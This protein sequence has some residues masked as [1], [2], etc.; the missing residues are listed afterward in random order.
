VP[1]KSAASSAHDYII[2][3]AG[4][5]GCV[6]ANRL[7]EDADASVLLVEAGGE[8]R[9]PFARMPLANPYFFHRPDINWNYQSER[10]PGL[11]G[12]Q[13][14]LP[15]G[16]VL[17]GSS[18]I[19]GMAF[20]RGHRRD[21]DDWSDQGAEGWSYSEVLPYFRRLETSWAGANEYHGDSGPV[22]IERALHRSLRFEELRDAALAA[23]H[24]ETPDYHGEVSEGITRPE[25]TTASGRRSD[26]AQ[27][28]LKPALRRRN[29]TLL[30]HATVSKVAL[31][32]QRAIGVDVHHGGLAKRIVASREV[33]LCGGAYNSPHLLLLSG[34]GPAADLASMGITPQVDLPGVGANLIEHPTMRMSFTT[35]PGTLLDELRIDRAVVS[36]LRWL[37]SGRGAFSVNGANGMLYLRTAPT[38]DR[39]DIQL[40]CT[41]VSLG[42]ALWHPWS[43]PARHGLG[44]LVT[45]IRQD[46]RGRVSLRSADPAAAPKILLNLL[47]APRDLSRLITATRMTRDVYAQEPLRSRHTLEQIP[48]PQIGSDRELENHLRANVGVTH[49]PVGTCRM[50][51]DEQAV[52]DPQLKVRGVAG[53]RVVDASVMP[54]I[55]GGNT[56][57][58]TIMIAEKAADLIGGR[59]R[60]NPG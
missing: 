3:G 40:M 30:T 13:L 42:A 41:G 45:L 60:G 8:L 29:L 11:N 34:I 38:E 10:E 12:R 56:N 6:L 23:G 4:S 32:R 48:G 14:A 17:G 49:H 46:S 57:A 1:V 25:L 7:S 58:P 36:T 27:A 15:R 21:Y 43:A 51:N 16:R 37:L 50:G 22:H 47:T 18:R 24:R 39:P 31:E 52:V 54:C 59:I 33:I 55:P 28:Y 26:T 9:N 35:D 53:L 2:V 20:A 5:A 19:N 44:A